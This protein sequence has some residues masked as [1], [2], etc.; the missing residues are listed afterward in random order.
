MQ[1]RNIPPPPDPHLHCTL[2]KISSMCC[3]IMHLVLNI[4]RQ[5]VERM[6][7]HQF[8]VRHC[9]TYYS[10]PPCCQERNHFCLNPLICEEVQ[11]KSVQWQPTPKCSAVRCNDVHRSPTPGRRNKTCRNQENISAEIEKRFP[12]EKAFAL[13]S[14]LHVSQSPPLLFPTKCLFGINCLTLKN[15]PWRL[16]P[17]TL[18]IGIIHMARYKV[19]Y[20]TSTRGTNQIER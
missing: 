4:A 12:A 17:F 11:C 13:R 18:F 14:P 2:A 6:I 1:F 5:F 20:S 15:V 3:F 19:H 8:A 9:S 16:S 7:L 10:T